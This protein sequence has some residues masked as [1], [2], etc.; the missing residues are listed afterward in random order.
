MPAITEHTEQVSKSHL[1]PL[2]IQL[3]ETIRSQ[4][5]SGILKPGQSLPPTQELCKKYHISHITVRQA[6]VDLTREG[7]LCRIPSRGTFV[8]DRKNVSSE[9]TL[10]LIIPD[11]ADVQSSQFLSQLLLGIKS[12]ASA[13]QAGLLLYTSHETTF[14]GDIQRGKVQGMILTNPQV[15]DIR[16][17]LLKQEKAALVVVGRVDEEGVCTVDN[18]NVW[19]GAQLTAHLL[20]RG[21]R[22]I[23]L[24]NSPSHLTVS[25]D[26][27]RGYEQAL[28]EAGVGMD[29]SL[30]RHGDFSRESGYRNG[31][32]LIRKG[33]E[34]LVCADDLVGLGVFEAAREEGRSIPG[35]LAVCGC[36]NSA[37]SLIFQ[38][39][40]TTVDINAREIGAQA[41]RKLLARIRGCSVEPRTLIEGKLLSRLSTTGSTKKTFSP[42]DCP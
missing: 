37:F 29:E 6:L 19:V 15:E 42:F 23:G 26:R 38:P 17:R 34:A 24:V 9:T 11:Q 28:N 41:A 14:L 35:Q 10:G 13:E 1:A 27:F 20:E 39:P 4:I 12:V 22:K 7:L 33:V 32:E 8:N 16:I 3:K 30:V 31:K 2:Y 40:M 25:Q 18:D 5:E 36:N 21:H